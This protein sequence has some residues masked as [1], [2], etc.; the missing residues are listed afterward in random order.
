MSWRGYLSFGAIIGGLLL[1]LLISATSVHARSV[2]IF[3]GAV[4][5]QRG[6][7]EFDARLFGETFAVRV[8][9]VAEDMLEFCP[10]YRHEMELARWVSDKYLVRDADVMIEPVGPWDNGKI[11]ARVS[12]LLDS[13]EWTDL[14]PLLP[15]EASLQVPSSDKPCARA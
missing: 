9:G 11:I 4:E 10:V 6:L 12:V 15:T 14:L 7:G 1:L 8:Y 5:K 3:F 13:G 2:T